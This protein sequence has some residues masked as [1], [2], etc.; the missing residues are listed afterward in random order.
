MMAC[1]LEAE[2]GMGTRERRQRQFAEREQLII[3]A[4]W[5]SIREEGLLNL[6][7]SRLAK[8]CEYAVGTLYQHFA[9]KEDLL[10]ALT[11]VTAQE[12]VTMFQRVMDWQAS[13]RD[14]MFALAVA[15]T[16]FVQRNPDYF[17]VAQYCQCEVVWEAASP[18]RR[19]ALLD[20]ID[21]IGEIVVG[22]VADAE[23]AGD[24]ELR[25][26]TAYQLGVGCWALSDGTHNLV[27][28]EGVLRPAESGCPYRLMCRHMQ[29]LLNGYGWRPLADPADDQALDALIERITREV[30][31]DLCEPAQGHGR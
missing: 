1:F 3:E 28:S 30:F 31:A 5:N 17:R 26:L 22:V 21:L 24:L 8:K 18:E 10:L 23:R 15:D 25:G 20:S 12:H 9:S 16:I 13:P 7:M 14:R 6:Q 11:I 2:T 29:A 27:H 19:Q 4:A